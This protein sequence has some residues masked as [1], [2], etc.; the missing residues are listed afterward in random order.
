[1]C[2]IPDLL[3][4]AVGRCQDPLGSDQSSTAEVLIE[5]VDERH[6]PTP[7]ARSSVLT[8]DD[9]AAAVRPLHAADVLVGHRML[10]SRPGAKLRI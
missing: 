4:D 10:K 8:T 3:C 9:S 6:L 2:L 1:M 5:R 7:F